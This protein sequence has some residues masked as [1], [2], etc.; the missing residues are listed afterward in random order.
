MKFNNKGK[1]ISIKKSEY[2]DIKFIWTISSCN[3]DFE[4]KVQSYLLQKKIPATRKVAFELGQAVLNDYK[5][6]NI[7]E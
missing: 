6:L 1:C 2:E 7:E 5:Y 4:E 3:I